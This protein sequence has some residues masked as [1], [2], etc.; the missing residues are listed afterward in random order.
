MH[1]TTTEKLF[2]AR[3][4]LEETQAEAACRY[5]VPISRYISWE[6]G[7]LPFPGRAPRI[8]ARQHEWCVIMRIRSGKTQRK[9]AEEIG[10]T[11]MWVR[12][13]ETGKINCDR[14]LEYWRL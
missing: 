11:R 5:N 3:R 13:M 10:L 14:L 6:K 7:N 8:T 2:L 12:N 1:L 4:R 9:V